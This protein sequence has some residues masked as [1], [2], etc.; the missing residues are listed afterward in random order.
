LRLFWRK[1]NAK[2]KWRL[3]ARLVDPH[4]T[5]IILELTAKPRHVPP[6]VYGKIE[7]ACKIENHQH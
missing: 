5:K 6:W 2:K 1:G 3:R 4:K 7:Y